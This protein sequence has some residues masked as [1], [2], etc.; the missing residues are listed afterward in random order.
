MQHLGKVVRLEDNC[1]AVRF[2]RTKACDHCGACAYIGDK[3]AEVILKNILQAQPGDYV[4][5]E[6]QAKG[7]LEASFLVYIVPLCMLIAGIAVGSIWSDLWG[8]LLGLFGAGLAYAGLRLL[9]P[10]FSKMQKFVPNMVSIEQAPTE[11]QMEE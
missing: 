7:F 10:K 2:E 3:E 6:M 11:I 8:A 9:E 4:R 5:V 1:A